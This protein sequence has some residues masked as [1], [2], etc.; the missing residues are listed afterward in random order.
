MQPQKPTQFT[1]KPPSRQAAKAPTYKPAEAPLTEE[2]QLR[3]NLE[4]QY[5]NL[6]ARLD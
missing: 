3:R 1:Y 4:T 2:Q 6:Q 5:T